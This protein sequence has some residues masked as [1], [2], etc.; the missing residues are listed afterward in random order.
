[1]S[2][3]YL[4]NL[5]VLLVDDDD[6]ICNLMALMLREAGIKNVQSINDSRHV[7]PFLQE[8]GASLVL[9]DLNMPYLSGHDLLR[10][11]RR[12]H[13]GIQVV[14]ISGANELNIAVEC[15]K[16][17]ALDYLSKPVEGTRLIA[18][19][20]N[21]LR[22]NAMQGELLSL[23]K[24]FL[25]DSLE[26]PDLFAAIITRNN[27]M[28]ALFQYAEVIARSPHPILI[29][30]ETGVGKELVA[31]AVHRLSGVSGEFVSV[32]VAG[33]DDATFS[34]VLFG[35]KKGAYTGADQ[36][37]EGLI[38]RAAGGTLFLDEIGDLEEKSQ[39][40]L[41]RL[42]QE[43]EYYSVG[44]DLLKKTTAH[45][46]AATNRNLAE[47]VAVNLFRRDLLYRLSMHTIQIPPLRER[48][49][50]IPLLLNH[51]LNEAAPA[52]N[53]ARP[54]VAADVLPHL[55]GWGFPGNV[56]E[57]RAMVFDAVARHTGG[58]LSA[59]A[60][61]QHLEEP[62][63]GLGV[64]AS[65]AVPERNIEMIFGHFPTVHEAEEYLI[66]EALRRSAGN[67]NVA[68][69]MLG[70]TRQ[71]IANRRKCSKVTTKGKK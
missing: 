70:I 1:M 15:M 27:K 44:S 3:A 64:T 33:L 60:F 12:E 8:H 59:S 38:C 22:I 10:A 47:R 57:L 35:H 42:L 63:Y 41:L 40:K 43:G 20:L 62:C 4:P 61:G 23:K 45:I 11:I 51:F 37:R 32:N 17:G 56:R 46:V 29:T 21:A 13:P 52:Y 53:K 31:Q 7:L 36:A 69:A 14:V 26:H 18:C 58:N 28:R 66:E 30:G 19:V 2:D 67:C 5:P 65:Q 24:R 25:E 55:L 71:T 48:P 68:A 34:D 49:E 39:I 16:L 6:S 50:D 9:L 54:A